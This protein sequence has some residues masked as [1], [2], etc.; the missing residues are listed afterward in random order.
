M[1]LYFEKIKYLGIL[2]KRKKRNG[3]SLSKHTDL[4]GV[5][6]KL[7]G[8]KIEIIE[9]GVFWGRGKSKQLGTK[10]NMSGKPVDH[11]GIAAKIPANIRP[12]CTRHVPFAAPPL[13][14]VT[15]RPPSPYGH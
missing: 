11:A 5:A 14:V 8:S 13:H 3:N 15:N 9:L 6:K 2:K 4:L 10:I 1:Y 7:L 12:I